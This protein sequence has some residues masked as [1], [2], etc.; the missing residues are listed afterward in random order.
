MNPLSSL[1]PWAT[2][3]IA[4]QL[5]VVLT[6][7]IV[8]LA[9]SVP[10]LVQLARTAPELTTAAGVVQDAP[11]TIEQVERIDGN[12]QDVVPS[13]L[14]VVEQIPLVGD[15]LTQLLEVAT[16]LSSSAAGIEV[17]AG[18]LATLSDEIGPIREQIAALQAQL[19]ALEAIGAPLDSLAVSAEPLPG[20]LADLTTAAVTIASLVD[21]V[22][23]LLAAI[24]RMEQHVANLDRKTGPVLLPDLTGVRR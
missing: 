5:V 18:T 20:Q 23:Q 22:P 4:V 8:G 15:Q 2:R 3:V 17:A 19:A 12:V 16:G 21:V 14:E 10:F 6:L 9:I 1:P 24:E 13:V 7:A 11:E